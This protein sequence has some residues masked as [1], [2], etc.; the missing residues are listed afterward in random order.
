MIAYP[1][2]EVTIAASLAAVFRGIQAIGSDVDR[3]GG[4]RVGSVLV[5]AMTVAGEAS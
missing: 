1:V 5:E 3:R 2:E 4:V